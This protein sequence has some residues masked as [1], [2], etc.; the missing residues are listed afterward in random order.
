MS[1]PIL[2]IN[3]SDFWEGFS[4][5]DNMFTNML[6]ENYEIEISEEPQLL[7]YSCYS[8]EFLK[9]DCPK[10]YYTAENTRPDFKECDFAF[11]FDYDHPADKHYRLPLYRW[12]GNLEAL[13]Q[14]K[15]VEAVIASKTKF[16]CMVVSNG[17]ATYRNEFYKK[18][19]EYKTVDSGGKYFNN[20]GGPVA[21]KMEFIKGYK[22][23]L[24]FE[25]SSYPGYTTE[26]II[27][28]MFANCI[29][30]YWG[31]TRVGEDFN[32]SS[33]VNVHQYSSMEEAINAIIAIDKDDTLYRQYV[34]APYYRN[35]I[36]PEALDFK[37]ISNALHEA[38]ERILSQP[39]VSFASKAYSER[40]IKKQKLKSLIKRIGF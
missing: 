4:K 38:V 36:F 35:N 33:F 32:S 6:K 14:P 5:E 25:N 9:Y 15:D 12:N 18:L 20:V 10:I 7:F 28:P 16:C 17:S 1:K 2:K 29:P 3:F 40:K 30:V 21:D 23:V 11:T 24:S 26:K 22:F 37:N 39:A 13:T 8:N 27:E 19:N 34:A 31:S